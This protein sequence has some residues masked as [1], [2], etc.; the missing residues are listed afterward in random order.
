M[1]KGIVLILGIIVV[2]I[3]AYFYLYKEHR[4]IS[5][6][7]SS[8]VV[9]VPA[10]FEEF[11]GNEKLATAKYLDKTVEVNGLLSDLDLKENVLQLDGKLSATLKD[12]PSD[13][14]R[15]NEKVTIKGRL[16]GY[17]SL[18]EEIKMDEC[19]IIK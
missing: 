7:D 12:K 17:D 18:L 15:L 1:K 8:Y 16:I 19:T 3:S 11:A 5:D 2:L 9:N 14:V 13:P 10:L 4:N 6:E